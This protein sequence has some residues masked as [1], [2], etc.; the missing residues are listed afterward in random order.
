MIQSAARALYHAGVPLDR[1][2]HDPFV[3]LDFTS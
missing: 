1:I 3:R 2:H